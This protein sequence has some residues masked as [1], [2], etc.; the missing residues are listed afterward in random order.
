MLNVSDT[1][2]NSKLKKKL[3]YTLKILRFFILKNDICK[4]DI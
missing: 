4:T 3:R 1:H 2:L